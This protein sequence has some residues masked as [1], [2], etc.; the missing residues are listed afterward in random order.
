MSDAAGGVHR[1]VALLRCLATAAGSGLR[2]KDLADAVALPRPTAHRM[3][4]SLM[5]EG[6]V[7][8]DADGKVYRLGLDLFVLA[9]HAG[10]PMNLRELCRP[11][12]AASDGV[13]G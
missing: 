6:M 9:A 11:S 12:P 13:A 2:L 8:R 3:L 4:A 1:T 10:N 5:A 7:E